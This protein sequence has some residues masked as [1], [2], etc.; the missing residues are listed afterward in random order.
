MKIIITTVISILCF[1]VINTPVYADTPAWW[2]IQSIDTMKYSRDLARQ[3]MKNPHFEDTINTQVKNIAEAGANYIAIGTPYDEEFNSFLKLWVKSARKYN[4]HVW[5]RG[6]FSGWEGWFGYKNLSREEHTR[7]IQEFIFRNP[8]LFLDGDIFSSCPECENGGP[9]DPRTTGDIA[10]HRA[11]LIS[12]YEVTKDAFITIGKDVKSNYFS[13]NGDVALVTLDSDTTKALNGIIVVDHYVDTP[14]K[15]SHDI[16]MF[17]KS[18]GGKVMLG[19]FGVPVPDIH[20]KMTEEAQAQWITKALS[21]ISQNPE[22]IGVNYWV[23]SGGT[24][25]I[26]EKDGK[27]RIAVGELSKY[28]KPYLLSGS[29]I[30]DLHR[31]LGGARIQYGDKIAISNANGVFTIPY[32]STSGSHLRVTASGYND[33]EVPI[34]FGREHIDLNLV[35]IKKSLF[36]NIYI[37]FRSIFS[38]LFD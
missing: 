2:A 18:S 5:F 10:G 21:L 14:E 36:D 3:E 24:T 13:M 15:L 29:V 1:M 30:N 23:G 9:G 25:G 35:K 22:L 4:L 8:D 31:P 38:G 19:E 32:V 28:F 16:E 11:F 34:E 27:A 20:G 6:N 37:T 17:A 7:K 26:W 33:I 12:E